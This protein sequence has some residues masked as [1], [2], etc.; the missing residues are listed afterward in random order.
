MC[1]Q[2]HANAKRPT[3]TD[4]AS[5]ANVSQTTVSLVLNHAKGARISPRTR[6]RVIT[7]ANELGYLPVLRGKL[8]EASGDNLIGFICD[9]IATDPWT[10]IEFQGVRERAWERGF[11]VTMMSTRGDADMER[12]VFAQL[13]QLS[14]VGIIYATINTRIIDPPAA[15][16]RLPAV[17]LNCRATGGGLP[18]I[19]P[20]EVSGGYSATDYLLRAGHRRIGYI[21]GEPGMAASRQ[22]LRG[23]R[24][25]LA[26][27]DLPFDPD[28]VKNGNWEPPSGYEHTYAL[29]RLSA[30]PTAI[31]C[32]ND[33]MAIGCY[34]ALRELGIRIPDDVAVMGYDDREIARHLHPPLT[35]VLLPHLE[36]GM[37]A[38]D[39]LLEQTMGEPRRL[40]EV[41]VECPVV[42]R[43][44]V[45]HRQSEDL[46][47]HYGSVPLGRY[48]SAI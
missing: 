3:M 42:T 1:K 48:L 36:M 38:T 28:L 32:A 12:A 35:T 45:S 5:A 30:P 18:S 10:A 16:S 44:S 4:V 37:L 34:E 29:M 6:E 13:E 24:Q 47:T 43:K 25:A 22:R 31:F 20:G 26:T 33:L 17:L 46:E 23:Y 39:M 9:E 40:R 2:R 41:E 21:N 15:L 27:A 8:L 19:V 14:P 7:T 11:A